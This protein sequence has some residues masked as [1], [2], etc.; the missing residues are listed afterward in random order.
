MVVDYLRWLGRGATSNDASSYLYCTLGYSVLRTLLLPPSC[1]P[2][3]LTF[4]P[5]SPLSFA[6]GRDDHNRGRRTCHMLP[7]SR[8]FVAVFLAA[9]RF[10]KHPRSTMSGLKAPTRYLHAGP[11]QTHLARSL[12]VLIH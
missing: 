7:F 4:S 10:A 9:R 3:I 8:P 5:L 11:V 6:L 1:G 12:S 2:V